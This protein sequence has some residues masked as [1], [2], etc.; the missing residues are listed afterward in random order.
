[1]PHQVSTESNADGVVISFLGVV[2][3]DELVDLNGRLIS[4]ESFSRV[5]YQ[6]WDFS[7]ATRLDLEIEEL[8]SI[9]L[10]DIA[11]SAANPSLKVAIVGQPILFGGR[12]RIFQ[13]FEEVWTTYRPELF[14]DVEAAREWVKS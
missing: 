14:L 10:Q 12:D 9:S 4:E 8:R 7:S 13:I 1:M 5:R 3:G 2:S 6:I 11:A